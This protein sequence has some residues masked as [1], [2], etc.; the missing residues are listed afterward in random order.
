MLLE[1]GSMGEDD[2]LRLE[3]EQTVSGLP[4]LRATRIK[5]SAKVN[6]CAAMRG[7]D[8]EQVRHRTGGKRKV[9]WLEVL[10]QVGQRQ[11]A[12]GAMKQGSLA[13]AECPLNHNQRDVLGPLGRGFGRQIAVQPK[14][15][16]AGTRAVT[17]ARHGPRR[18]LWVPGLPLADKHPVRGARGDEMADLAQAVQFAAEPLGKA[19]WGI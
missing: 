4:H 13:V 2:A 5:Q 17:Q 18:G 10:R 11:R 12:A 9:A 8:A 14:T 1:P 15:L 3:G 19:S 16:A 7:G 6:G